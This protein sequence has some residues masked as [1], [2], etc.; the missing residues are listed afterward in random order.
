MNI[1]THWRLSKKLLLVS[2]VFAVVLP[3]AGVALAASYDLTIDYSKQ[4]SLEGDPG[5]RIANVNGAW[6][7]TFGESISAGTGTFN[8]SMLTG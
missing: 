4:P 7:Q 8:T 1:T 6:W 2:L 5:W 3:M